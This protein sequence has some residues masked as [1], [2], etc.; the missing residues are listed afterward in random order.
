MKLKQRQRVVAVLM[1]MLMV[2]GLLPANFTLT[3]VKAA[4]KTYVLN[5]DDQAASAG[6]ASSI[7]SGT[8]QYFTLNT[9]LKVTSSPKTIDDKTFAQRMQTNGAGTVDSKSIAFTT[10]G[11]A[12]ITVYAA[13]SGG[14]PGD[15]RHVVLKSGDT[16]VATSPDM[17]KA[18]AANPTAPAVLKFEFKGNIT[19]AGTYYLTA[20]VS[21]I[22]IY[23]VAVEEIVA[24]TSSAVTV[25]NPTVTDKD[26]T[27][28]TLAWEEAAVSGTPKVSISYSKDGGA[29]VELASVDAGQ[30]SYDINMAD[31][32]SGSYVF[33]VKG[34]ATDNVVSASAK[35]WT[36]PRKAWNT[37]VAP[38]A[39]AV[40]N[41]ANIDVKWTMEI[42][43]DGADSLDVILLKA[44]TVIDTKSQATAG[45]TGVATFT[46]ISSSGEYTVKL[47]AKR[48][49]ETDKVVDPATT[50]AYAYALTEPTVISATGNGAD[51]VA[52]TWKSV[53]EAD[54]YT[55]WYKEDGAAVYTKAADGITETKYTVT[56]LTVGKKY[57]FKIEAVRNN[58][59]ATQ[60]ALYN[61]TVT[62]EVERVWETA[63][64]GT[65][66]STNEKDGYVKVNDNGSVSMFAPAGKLASS[67]DGFSFYYTKVKSSDE[68]FVFK[69][70]MVLDGFTGDN[71]S[72]AGLLVADTIGN[73][74]SHDL[75]SAMNYLLAGISKTEWVDSVTGNKTTYS[76]APSLRKVLGCTDP[77]G[78]V[79]TGRILSQDLYF[80]DNLTNEQIITSANYTAGTCQ[81]EFELTLVKDNNGYHASLVGADGT[82]HSYD[83]SKLLKQD[84]EYVYVGFAV[85]RNIKATFKDISFESRKPSDDPAKD[86]STWDKDYTPKNLFVY[87]G[88]TTSQAEYNYRYYGN[89]DANVTLKDGNGNVIFS[90]DVVANET[91]SYDMVL[92]D[93]TTKLIT[94]VTPNPDK[95]VLASY[96]PVVIEKSV[97]MNKIGKEGETLI[98]SPT[99][100]STGSGTA[101]NPLDIY[102]AVKYAQPGQTI[103]LKNGTYDMSSD[104]VIPYSVSGKA[105]KMITMI[106]E[107]PGK[108]I[109]N[110]SNAENTPGTILQVNGDY[111]HIYGL[112][113]AYS[114]KNK[115]GVGVSGN[116]NIIELCKI[117][118]NGTTGLQISRS[119]GEP[120]E[121]W[122]KNNL[123]KNCDSYNNCDVALNDADGFA[124]KLTVGEGNKFYGCISYNNIDDGWDLY[125]KNEAGQGE[126][127]PVIIENCVAYNNGWVPG[128]DGLGEGNGFKLGG[129]G[130]PGAHQLINSVSFNNGAKGI[131]S[132]N[133]P[134]CQVI[135]STAFNNGLFYATGQKPSASANINLSP[136]NGSKY[137]GKTNYVLKNTI[138]YTTY[139]LAT[140][141][142]FT[143]VGQNALDSENN[144]I[145]KSASESSNSLGAKV[146]AD[147]FVSLDT[148]VVPTRNA[149]GTIDMHGLL[150]LTDKAP[151]G[152][153][154]VIKT[155]GSAASAKPEL[156]PT[157]GTTTNVYL[158]ITLSIM[159]GAGLVG[160]YFYDK[161]KR[162]M[163]KLA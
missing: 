57:N 29:S 75:C 154:A 53:K 129:E 159:S 143:L 2:I 81:T 83:P 30:K 98:V 94:T 36:Q 123:V 24:D 162:T 99:G 77:T 20:D 130:L 109:L 33:S 131:A 56:G 87:A 108:V 142:Q 141:D 4:N 84:A 39:T 152:V 41:G 7:K 117:H 3:T 25:S 22:D 161:K 137:S 26:A 43:T 150:V 145:V 144:Y 140:A 45:T 103:L 49:A 138:S 65:Q 1:A 85:S 89:W 160:L 32:K 15:I 158:F 19:E 114:A 82:R 113:I 60:E 38:T 139:S 106:A 73:N 146:S 31:L 132:N 14:N 46:S 91:I 134:D 157:T 96:E 122:P 135:N 58:P 155:D 44:G 88:A 136:L 118:D 42:G 6:L 59:A 13:Q 55:V 17:Q 5:A 18:G 125:A 110:G 37:V 147:W 128:V 78:V 64:V 119:G 10:T 163:S 101:A 97:T 66:A 54:S 48:D 16:T 148:S 116:N 86:E 126:I 76:C 156:P 47:V 104:L 151:A 127:S 40:Q 51:S 70:K 23:Y 120:K 61:K 74:G 63:Y 80:F 100:K 11:A 153:G 111:W 124:A 95:V 35:V 79:P 115:K 21:G 52:F 149:N 133:G 62:S 105:G 28:W 121:W 68:N 92:T 27:T 34:S 102:T 9:G 90:K 112:E 93:K 12:N 8:E 107:E 50:V 67:N 69:A 72:G 71:Q